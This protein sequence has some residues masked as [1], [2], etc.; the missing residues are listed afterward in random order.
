MDETRMSDLELMSV[1]D[2]EERSLPGKMYDR[3]K[4]STNKY[5]NILARWYC[6]PQMNLT[7]DTEDNYSEL[8]DT[9]AGEHLDN[10]ERIDMD[11]ENNND[12]S[13]D[14][15][16]DSQTKYLAFS[17]ENFLETEILVNEGEVNT[18]CLQKVKDDDDASITSFS[19]VSTVPRHVVFGPPRLKKIS[20]KQQVVKWKG[21]RAP[22]QQG[23]RKI[24]CEMHGVRTI[25]Y[26]LPDADEVRPEAGV[27]STRL[28]DN[29]SDDES[30]LSLQLNVRKNTSYESNSRDFTKDLHQPLLS[31]LSSSPSSRSGKSSSSSSSSQSSSSFTCSTCSTCS[32]SCTSSE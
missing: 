24:I 2:D 30:L 26:D 1:S 6:V 13:G 12:Y 29:D 31:D 21:T 7:F 9:F 4:S 18:E 16:D 3:N 5:L 11:N 27:K 23:P 25:S 8:S 28:S 19:S 20:F 17:I 32:R 10:T 22:K 14:N 15:D